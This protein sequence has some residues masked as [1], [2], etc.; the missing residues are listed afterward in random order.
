MA[1]ELAATLT[2]D[3]PCPVCGS[4][5]HPAPAAPQDGQPTRQDEQDAEALHEQAKT[6]QEAAAAVLHGLREQAATATG[7]AGDT[8]LTD[9]QTQHTTLTAELTDALN[10]AGDQGTVQEELLTLDS[11][12]TAQTQQHST[13]T[14]GLSA[15]NAHY[16][17]LTQQLTELTAKLTAARGTHPTVAAHADDLTRT[18]EREA[19]AREA[20]RPVCADCGRK[21]SDDRWATVDRRDWGQSRESHPHLCEDC[22]SRAVAAQQTNMLLDDLDVAIYTSVLG[23]RYMVHLLPVV[24]RALDDKKLGGRTP[25]LRGPRRRRT[26]PPRWCLWRP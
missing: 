23:R 1:A 6:T 4:C 25:D 11:E 13:A 8:P 9:L 2:D 5:T 18:A 24:L 14:A 15:R 21:F 17:T 26:A 12:H 16:D 19:A 10:R 22:Q 3:T 20:Q 7:E